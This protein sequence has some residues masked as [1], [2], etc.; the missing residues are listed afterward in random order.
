[1]RYLWR[2]DGSILGMHA[3]RWASGIAI[4]LR[5]QP[6][7]TVLVWREPQVRRYLVLDG[8]PR[9]QPGG[10]TSICPRSLFQQLVRTSLPGI[11]LAPVPHLVAGASEQA[12]VIAL[13]TR[14]AGLFDPAFVGQWAAATLVTTWL[15]G[16]GKRPAIRIGARLTVSAAGPPLVPALR[17][18]GWRIDPLGTW[19]ARRQ[20]PL[21]VPRA[22]G[23]DG[24]VSSA[25]HDALRDP[26]QC[27]ALAHAPDREAA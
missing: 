26:Q 10:C 6:L 18:V 27:L 13:P 8:C 14:T 2:L 7:T 9:C 15:Q 16:G 20:R 23:H 5:Y 12:P 11:T 19:L 22:V 3:E 17:A 25:L 4:H 24:P 1:M 21:L